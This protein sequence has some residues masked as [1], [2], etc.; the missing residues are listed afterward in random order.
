[1]SLCSILPSVLLDF[2]GFVYVN[3][4]PVRVC[5]VRYWFVMV[6]VL[7]D[8]VQA[9]MNLCVCGEIVVVSTLS[10]GLCVVLRLCDP[11]SVCVFDSV[12]L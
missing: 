12:E 3:F 4:R 9:L 6:S 5:A 10:V 11:L 1:V 7:A 2:V 8:S